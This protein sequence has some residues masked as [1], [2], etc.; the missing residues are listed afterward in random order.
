MPAPAAW[1]NLV[2]S[3]LWRAHLL[4]LQL[5]TCKRT[6]ILVAKSQEGHMRCNKN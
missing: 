4:H 5:Q 6:L 3:Q 2:V 1:V